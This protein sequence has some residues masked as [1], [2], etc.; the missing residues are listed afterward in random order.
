MDLVPAVPFVR[1]H[2]TRRL[3]AGDELAG[4]EAEAPGAGEDEAAAA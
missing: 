4:D 2:S 3:L 1:C